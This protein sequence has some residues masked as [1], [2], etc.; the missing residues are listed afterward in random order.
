M[1]KELVEWVQVI[2]HLPIK[3]ED[4]SSNPNINPPH[5]KMQWDLKIFNIEELDSRKPIAFEKL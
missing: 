5:Q 3:C 4:L 2:E 1:Q